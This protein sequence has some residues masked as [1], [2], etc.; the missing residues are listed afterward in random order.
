VRPR[1]PRGLPVARAGLPKWQVGMVYKRYGPCGPYRPRG[2]ARR[3]ASPG[4][5]LPA[6]RVLAGRVGAGRRQGA[7][8]LARRWGAPTGRAGCTAGGRAQ[9]TPW[10]GLAGRG[11]HATGPQRAAGWQRGRARHAGCQPPCQARAGW[12]R[13]TGAKAPWRIAYPACRL[14]ARGARGRA[15]GAAAGATAPW[16]IAYTV[17]RVHWW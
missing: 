8:G 2:A 7:V 9:A 12:R 5:A 17:G 3:L 10:W 13:A 16:R 15:G 1:G 6:R 11:R 4:A 14:P